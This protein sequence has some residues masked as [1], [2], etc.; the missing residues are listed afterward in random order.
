MNDFTPMTIDPVTLLELDAR[1]AV[2]WMG[3]TWNED[4]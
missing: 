4:L 3:W 1:I 2:E